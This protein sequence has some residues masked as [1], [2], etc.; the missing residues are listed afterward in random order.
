MGLHA[1]MS[2]ARSKS[3]FA[4]L[5]N[6]TGH[7]YSEHTRLPYPRPEAGLN[8]AMVRYDRATVTTYADEADHIEKIVHD[9]L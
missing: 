4:N 2:V 9:P 7:E 6:L 3:S 5:S 8:G 1:G